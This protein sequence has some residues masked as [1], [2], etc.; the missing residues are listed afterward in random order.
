MQSAQ[1]TLRLLRDNTEALI[2]VLET[3]LHDPLVEWTKRGAQGN[4]TEPENPRAKEVLMKISSRLQGVVVGVKAKE[5]IP[6]SVE[7]QARKLVEEASN[8]ESL[9]KMYIWW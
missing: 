9:S 4:A 1:E 8:L 7:G 3:F 6:L 5:S 2:G